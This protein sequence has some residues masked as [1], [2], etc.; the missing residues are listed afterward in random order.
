MEQKVGPPELPSGDWGSQLLQ[1]VSVACLWG[2]KSSSGYRD[3][4][5]Y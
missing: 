3:T 1:A 2:A 4:A 5:I